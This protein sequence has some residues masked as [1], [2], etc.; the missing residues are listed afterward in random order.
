[1]E[2]FIVDTPKLE[3]LDQILVDLDK[4]FSGAR[5][6]VKYVV[7]GVTTAIHS[8]QICLK[9]EL[10][11]QVARLARAGD[12]DGAV[13]TL[14]EHYPDLII[15]KVI[16]ILRLLYVSGD[17]LVSAIRFV[18]KM[19]E[20]FKQVAYEVLYEDVRLKGHTEMPEIL[21]LQRNMILAGGESEVLKQVDEDCNKIVDRIVE[22]VKTKNYELSFAIVKTL[23][24]SILEGKMALIVEK[25]HSAGTLEETLLLTHFS[26]KL[27]NLSSSLVFTQ[28]FFEVLKSKNLLGT[29]HGLHLLAYARGAT[30]HANFPTVDK[31]DQEQC[32]STCIELDKNKDVYFEIYRGYVENPDERK[33]R[34]VHQDNMLLQ[35]IVSEFVDFYYDGDLE[36]AC[37]LLSTAKNICYFSSRLQIM[38]SLYEKMAHF[39]QLNTFEA[40]RIFTLVKYNLTVSSSNAIFNHKF[41]ELQALAPPCLRLLLWPENAEA[42]F[43]LINKYFSSPLFITSDSKI[44]CWLPGTQ[45]ENQLWSA[46]VDTST[47]LTTFKMQGK[48]VCFNLMNGKSGRTSVGSL[49]GCTEWKIKAAD[50]NHVKLYF[51]GTRF[52]VHVF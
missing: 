4:S 12:L 47:G 39:D 45:S 50:E 35:W 3:M 29:E 5:E 16:D 22:G 19:G 34:A 33:I 20:Q 14:H 25:V 1:M 27:L 24:S 38:K 32:I 9:C 21:L 28:A 15:G 17:D 36:K 48:K 26:Q 51:D 8:L 42:K 46:H 23:S 52:C 44:F 6:G 37:A 43:R 31:C 49:K 7:S 11:E 13:T 40:F 10:S 2:C 30:E 41:K 18:E